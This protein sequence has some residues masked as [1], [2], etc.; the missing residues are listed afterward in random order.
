MAAGV[1]IDR[2]FVWADL[3][4]DAATASSRGDPRHRVVV[5]G[6]CRPATS[7]TTRPMIGMIFLTSCVDIVDKVNIV[8]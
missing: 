6:G 5:E 3:H 7:A 8:V 4:Q 1:T 2:T